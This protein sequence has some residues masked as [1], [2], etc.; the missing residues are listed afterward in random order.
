MFAIGYSQLK[1]N[2][3]LSTLCTAMLNVSSWPVA[4]VKVA[5]GTRADPD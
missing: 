2:D 1:L 3:R 4:P 5:R